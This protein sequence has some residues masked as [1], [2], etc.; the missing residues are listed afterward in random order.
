MS[1]DSFE[2]RLRSRKVLYE[3]ARRVAAFSLLAGKWFLTPEERS[4]LYQSAWLR[5]IGKA[6][7]PESLL[8]KEARLAPFEQNALR[9]HVSLGVLY[10]NRFEL[11]HK[12]ATLEAI[13]A[14]HIQP[15]GKGYPYCPAARVSRVAR[16][17]R[18]IDVFVALIENRPY[19]KALSLEEALEVLEAERG[20]RL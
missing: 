12:E 6:F 1:L 14:H 4:V 16:W 15:D 2:K 9:L 8:Q 18:T 19:R 3:H 17:L 10:L 13:A 11:P 20:T 7:L 5:G